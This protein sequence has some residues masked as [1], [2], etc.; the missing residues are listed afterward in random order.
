MLKAATVA[1]DVS[2]YP[3]RSIQL[4]GVNS[5]MLRCN[6]IIARSISTARQQFVWS[7]K[8]GGPKETHKHVLF[9]SRCVSP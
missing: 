8:G 9:N 7:S 6:H 3:H 4:M 1:A 2:S 5:T